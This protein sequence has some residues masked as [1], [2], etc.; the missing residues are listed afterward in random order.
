MKIIKLLFSGAF[1]GILLLVFAYAIGYA[2]FVENDYGA[3][4]A[5]VLVYNA[6]WFEVL[7]VLM[8]VNFTG[9]I[10]TKHLYLQQKLNILVIHV[11]LVIIILGAGITRYFGYEGIMHIRDGQV[12]NELRT[13]DN[14]LQV[15]IGAGDEA[16]YIN[17]KLFLTTVRNELASASASWQG[18][19]YAV[20]VED[21]YNK[22]A[23]SVIPDANGVPIITI[24]LRSPNGQTEV[25]LK[26]GESN[27][28][29]NI[30]LTF[31]DNA[32][33]DYTQ[34]K[35]INDQLYIRNIFTAEQLATMDST[36]FIE[37]EYTPAAKMQVFI[38]DKAAFRITNFQK[39]AILKYQ[40]VTDPDMPGV[41]IVMVKVNNQERYIKTNSATRF[42][43][44]GIPVVVRVGAR[45]V[46]LPFALR[47]D[48]F[49]LE[50]Y[51]GSNSPSSFASDVTVIDEENNKEF[52]YRIFMNN[53]LDYGGFRFF[54]SSYDQDEKGTILSVNHD[55]WGTLVT[56]IGYFLL[57]TTLVLS[58]FTKTRFMR[59]N[60]MLKD[61]HARRKKLLAK[62]LGL[63]AILF[64]SAVSYAQPPV[65][66]KDHAA[67]FGKLFV[68]SNQG[69]I[70]PV[71]TLSSKMLVKISKKDSYKKLTS[72]QVILGLLTNSPAWQKEPL[73]KVPEEDIR[74]LIG[75]SGDLASFNDFIAADEQYKIGAQVEAAYQKKPAARSTFD[76]G[77]I[78]VDERVNVLYSL[79]SGNSFKIFP[80]EN[81]PN[82]TWV[83]PTQYHQ[84][85]GHGNGNADLFEGYSAALAKAIETSDYTEANNYLIQIKQMQETVGG[86]ILPSTT[87]ASVEI[88]YNK[89]NIFKKLFPVFMVL[90]IL[91]VGIFLLQIFYPNWE[92]KLL[93]KIL[94]IIMA[95]AFALQTIGL[96]ARWYI[97]GH[98]PWSNGYESM[99]YIAW[100]AVLAGFVFRKRS[101]AVLGV[102]ALLAGITLLTAHMSWL[103]PEVTNLVPVL[104]SYWLTF[105]V[106]TI[107]AS[108]GFLALGCMIGFL[109]LCI[110][111][112]RNNKNKAMV[113]LTLKELVLITEMSLAVGLVLLVIGN[114]LG[115]IWANES[116]GRYWGW[117]PKE[118]WTLVT[119]ILYSFTLHLTL[120]PAIRNTFTFSFFSF[121]SFGAVLMTYFGVN[122]YL[123]GLHSYANGDPVAIPVG[124][125]YALGVIAIISLLAAYNEF[126][127]SQ[128]E[129]V[130]EED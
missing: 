77:I 15:Q 53:V 40:P 32:K 119:V 39:K 14:Y 105:H 120:I 108:Y 130:K 107:T 56:Y 58:F 63:I 87:K 31:G 128:T 42:D 28:F 75:I 113:N 76:K 41:P 59:I 90:G 25:N 45:T 54:Q 26:Y 49:D 33:E 122:Y 84:K 51:P 24:Q 99:I 129:A 7:L 52:P 8:V 71:N 95:V 10:F 111:I 21:Y 123:S 91:L 101:S 103:N 117:D 124:L 61:V 48:K 94:F 80:L 29:E 55:Y 109:N 12:S 27:V 127:F 85:L 38:A 34:I 43:F 2:T 35:L 22:A 36:K 68:Q 23:Q 69:R 4:A 44:A 11:A 37:G 5:K 3:V 126:K 125:Y 89:A 100:A 110:M 64:I 67:Q 82:N 116:W 72:D 81:D 73:I 46:L 20:T 97:S 88:L 83:N 47:L 112:F 13:T 17:E 115:G 86:A 19:T 98:A 92:F 65:A 18:N 66:D 9:M 16:T 118:T 102:T 57:F 30:K 6:R 1:M 96:G 60:L 79:L 114:F 121:I 78:Y 70:E 50:R 106:A 93:G 62:T 104:K 74:R